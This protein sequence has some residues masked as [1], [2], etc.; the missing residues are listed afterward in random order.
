[1]PIKGETETIRDLIYYQYAKIIAKRAFKAGDGKEAKRQHF[2]FINN[3]TFQEPKGGIKSWSEI[4]REDWQFVESEDK[5][6][7]RVFCGREGR[8]LR[9]IR[10]FSGW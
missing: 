4:T 2:G 10:F 9:G 3:N 6:E 7:V 5:E 8:G 1:M